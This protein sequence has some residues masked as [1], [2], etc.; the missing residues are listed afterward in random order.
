MAENGITVTV[1]NTEELEKAVKTLTNNVVMV[2][3]PG[4]STRSDGGP[5][6]ATLG[7][8]HEYGSPAKNIP[9]RPW[10]HPPIAHMSA[11][12]A[13]RL[14]EAADLQLKFKGGEAMNVLRGLGMK[15]RDAVKNNM[16][17]GGDPVFTPIAAATVAAR[18]RRT[19]AGARQLAKLA[20][21]D[22][23]AWGE[24]TTRK[25]RRGGRVVD[26]RNAPP[27]RDTLD[28]FKAITYVIRQK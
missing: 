5:N 7:Y 14:G 1:D 24:G 2:G 23:K 22:L 15:A 3:I 11:E 21:Q 8:I 25:T 20:G 16:T 27:L 18:L 10:L 6:N 13:Q 12:I 9:A 26:E 17:A 28:M 4:D 19:R